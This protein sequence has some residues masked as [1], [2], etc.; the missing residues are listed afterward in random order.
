[1]ATGTL[2]LSGGYS[3]RTPGRRSRDAGKRSRD[4]GVVALIW[5]GERLMICQCLATLDFCP[6]CPADRALL[7]LIQKEAGTE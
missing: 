7:I 6:F 1:M 3:Q 5:D 4:G 2:R